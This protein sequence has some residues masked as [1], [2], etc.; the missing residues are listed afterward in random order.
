[1]KSNL[2]IFD[3]DGTIADT[4]HFILDLSDK[5]AEQFNFNKIKPNEVEMLKNSTVLE[6]INHLKVPYLKIPQILLE[7]RKALHDEIETIEPI[8]GLKEILLQLKSFGIKMGILTTNSSKNVMHFLKNHDLDIFDFI[9][10]T[11]MV[12]GKDSSIK[13]IVDKENLPYNSVLYIGDETRDVEAAQKAGVK[14]AAV[15]WGY[16]SKKA[17]KN[18][19]PDYLVDEPQELIELC[20]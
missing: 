9:N 2:L 15:T 8:Q 7:A 20:T 14:V 11:S 19:Q 3:F 1:M 18:H 5:L 13:K 17:L 6:T 12:W 16:N 4:F 10:T